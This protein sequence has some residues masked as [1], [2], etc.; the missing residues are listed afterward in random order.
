[1]SVIRVFDKTG[2]PL[3]GGDIDAL[4]D[5]PWILNGI[6][7]AN[8]TIAKTDASC[9]DTLLRFGN[10]ILIQEDD[11]GSWGGILLPPRNW[12]A[13]GITFAAYTIEKLLEHRYP[14]AS[15]YTGYAGDIFE[16]L[17]ASANTTEDTL[18]DFGTAYAGGVSWTEEPT[19]TV[20][21]AM[22]TIAKRTG[23]DWA[24]EP[25]I[26]SVGKL[27]WQAFW[28]SS[29]GQDLS[30]DV[31]FEEGTHF[32]IASG[33]LL[34]EQGPIYN[35]IKLVKYDGVGITTTATAT[36]ATSIAA[37]GTLQGIFNETV[38]TGYTVQT[39]CDY[40]LSVYKEP[41]RTFKLSVIND[42]VDTLKNI[43]LGNTIKIVLVTYGFTGNGLGTTA[44]VRI[45]AIEADE[46]DSTL[47]LVVN[48]VA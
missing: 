22:T 27:E 4:A 35:S 44:K 23:Q 28:Y 12:T 20:Y 32:K 30:G 11:M 13:D 15:S 9:T 36:D 8:I 45:Q 1:V 5:R 14:G 39:Y 34:S 16:D 24:I 26:D 17:I 19:D 25:Q 18:I 40:L 3:Q 6:G 42:A 31:V 41:R 29:R 21:K 33:P 46:R 47:T 10:R 37:Y 48:E 2:V 43:R 38:P 7:Q